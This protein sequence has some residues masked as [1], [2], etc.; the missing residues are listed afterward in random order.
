[1]VL[2]ECAHELAHLERMF[3]DCVHGSGGIAAVT[4]VVAAGKTELL[5]TIGERSARSG[6][7]FLLATG[8]RAE[9]SLPLGMLRQLFDSTTLD[10]GTVDELS[11]IHI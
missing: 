1:M 9:R 7:H 5:N 11:L 2:V 6:A 8:S 3:A 10:G 4:G